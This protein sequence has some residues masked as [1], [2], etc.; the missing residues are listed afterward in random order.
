MLIDLITLGLLALAVWKGI[1][2]GLVL[3]VFSLAAFVIGLAAALKLS[4]VAASWL[5]VNTELPPKWL[6]LVAFLAVF[7]VVVMLVNMVARLFEST[8]EWASMAWLNKAGGVIFFAVLHLLVWSILLFYLGKME[9]L[10][11]QSLDQSNTYPIIAPWGPVTMEWLGKVIPMFSDVFDDLGDFFEKIS[12]G[13]SPG[14]APP[15]A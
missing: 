5:A 9:I 13:L 8:I 3:A 4:A 15:R 10:G 1:R 11:E 12:T 2:R 6:P 14:D 7:L